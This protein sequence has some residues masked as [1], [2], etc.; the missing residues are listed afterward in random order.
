MV[1]ICLHLPLQEHLIIQLLPESTPHSSIEAISSLTKPSLERKQCKTK[2][3]AS[4][5]LPGTPYKTFIESK[6]EAKASK[7]KGRTERQLKGL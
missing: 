5:I 2:S 6:I 3:Q 1:L 4:E 7:M